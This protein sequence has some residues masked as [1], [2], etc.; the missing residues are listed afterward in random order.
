[1]LAAGSLAGLLSASEAKAEI[2]WAMSNAGDGNLWELD[3][4]AASPTLIGAIKDPVDNSVGSGWST[5]AEDPNKTLYFLRRF[6]SNINVY[7]L[8]STA[9]SVS[10]GII[11]NVVSLG[12]TRLQGNLDGLTAGPDGKIYFSGYDQTNG[13]DP[14]NGLWRFD[15]KTAK[16]AFVG[17]FAGDAGPSG[18]NSFYTDLAFD[19]KT[20]DLLG[21][22][23]DSSG[24]F[25]LYRIPGAVAQGAVNAT[26]AYVDAFTSWPYLDGLAF[27]RTGNHL[28]AS[29]DTGGVAEVN[30]TTG[31]FIQFI[32]GTGGTGI[33]TDLAVQSDT[34]PVRTPEPASLGLLGLALGGLFAAR[35]RRSR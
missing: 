34:I 30:P 1:M 8:D 20:G 33:G 27:D 22:G 10:G 19:P 11:Q 4:T 23:F 29:S 35:R 24:A 32:S 14:V 28:Y 25:S 31:A 15:P 3:T 13:T 6:S 21:T 9:I 26:F 18:A 17:T 7:S 2:V 5:V 16:L 12:A